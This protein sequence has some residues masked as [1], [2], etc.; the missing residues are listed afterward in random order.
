M[1]ARSAK[2][3]EK[4]GR[5]SINPFYGRSWCSGAEEATR[6]WKMRNWKVRKIWLISCTEGTHCCVFPKVSRTLLPIYFTLLLVPL[7]V[8]IPTPINQYSSRDRGRV[9]HF[10]FFKWEIISDTS[11]GAKCQETPPPT[12]R[13]N[14]FLRFIPYCRR[15]PGKKKLLSPKQNCV[16]TGA[17]TLW[18]PRE[19]E[20]M[21]RYALCQHAGYKTQVLGVRLKITTFWKCSFSSWWWWWWC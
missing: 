14:N 15:L 7:Q 12:R 8:G 21:R 6:G 18:R 9:N 20:R 5:K 13:E 19:D 4:F 10:V 16:S 17:G 2:N 3:P 1:S 11:G